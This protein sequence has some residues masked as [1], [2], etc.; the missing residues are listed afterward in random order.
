M[1]SCTSV[2]T[3]RLLTA[4]VD[5]SAIEYLGHPRSKCGSGIPRQWG[6]IFQANMREASANSLWFGAVA[7]LRH[8]S[9]SNRLQ[10]AQ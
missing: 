1:A 8:A 9:N 3:R 6:Q 7:A 10:I 5:V 2:F 4:G